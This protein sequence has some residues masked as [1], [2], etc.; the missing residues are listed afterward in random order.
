MARNDPGTFPHSSAPVRPGRPPARRYTRTVAAGD[1]TT[2]EDA[3][4]SDAAFGA[5]LWR[6]RARAGLSQEALAERAGVSARAIR[7]L[8][9][10]R[11]RQPHPHTLSALAQALGLTQAE[12]L[13]AA[14]AAPPAA[15]GPAPAARLSRRPLW[16]ARC[17][18]RPRR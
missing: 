11:R 10:G 8:E 12:V 7:T 3:P 2:D 17:L 15:A 1:A 5:V 18:S 16:R 4:A 9:R 14:L 13:L 6:F